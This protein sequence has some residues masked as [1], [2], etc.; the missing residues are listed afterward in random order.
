V[1]SFV[2]GASQGT[3][4]ELAA[5]EEICV[6]RDPGEC[7][8]VVG[9]DGNV[10]RVHCYIA[11]DAQ[12]RCCFIKDVSSNGTFLAGGKRLVKNKYY[13]IQPG[14]T[15]YLASI[16]HTLRVEVVDR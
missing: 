2:G 5:G 16:S 7:Q 3:G 12:Q 6:G 4:R 1:V 11:F 13:P 9:D 8:L 15:F 14:G 10:S